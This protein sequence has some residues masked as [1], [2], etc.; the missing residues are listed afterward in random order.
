MAG[1]VGL[2]YHTPPLLVCASFPP[3]G[4]GTPPQ[5]SLLVKTFQ[6]LFPALSPNT[7]NLSSA[8]RVVLLSYDAETETISFRHYLITIKPYGVSKRIRK[9]VDGLSKTSAN[10]VLDLGKEND[11]ADFFLRQRGEHGPDDEGYESATSATSSVAGDD[12]DAAVDLPDDYVGRNNRKGERRAVKLDEIGPRFDF[13]LLKMTEGLPGREGE[14]IYHKFVKKTKGETA[15]QKADHAAK[16]KLKKQRREEQER[17]VAVKQAKENPV[18]EDD[19]WGD[20][21]DLSEVSGDDSE[22][23]EEEVAR[24]PRPTKKRKLPS[25][26]A[27]VR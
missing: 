9:V 16:A 4:P 25:R 21:A 8:R 19:E 24:P 7:L 11:I 6:S 23:N 27:A 14:V 18:D 26:P 1:A 5:V 13:S 17:N 10:N 12:P 3:P 20:D 2:E 15:R 22:E